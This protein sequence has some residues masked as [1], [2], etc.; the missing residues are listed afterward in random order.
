[1]SEFTIVV[2]S[3]EKKPYHFRRYPV[4][5]I[6]KR[7]KTGDY[8]VADDGD[9]MGSES[10]DPHYAVERKTAPDFLKSI[11]W[12]RDRFEDELARADS[13]AHRMPIVIEKPWIHFER[14][15]YHQNVNLNSIK[16]TLDWHPQQY[17]VEY[18]FERDRRMG[19]QTTYEF[20][21][22]REQK[23]EERR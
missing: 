16:G 12:E 21:K 13:F 8:C 19:E 14:E 7:L 11:T 17:H 3:R 23:L 20:L 9:E 15:N 10:F 18:F 22:W 6:S 1:M 2:D 4:D 5:T